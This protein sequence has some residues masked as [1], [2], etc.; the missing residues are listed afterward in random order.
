MGA[1]ASSGVDVNSF[2]AQ[3]SS[4]VDVET[5]RGD[6]ARAEVARLRGLLHAAMQASEGGSVSGAADGGA[7]TAAA[8]SAAAGAG[9]GAGEVA[10]T[11]TAVGGEAGA[12]APADADATAADADASAAAVAAVAAEGE[13]GG[14]GGG[15]VAPASAPVVTV[16]AGGDGAGGGNGG[17]GTTKLCLKGHTLV[18]FTTDMDGF[19]CSKCERTLPAGAIMYGSGRLTFAQCVRVF[20]C[21][22]RVCVCCVCAPNELMLVRVFGVYGWCVVVGCRMNGKV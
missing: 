9:A 12:E 21:V 19:G 3:A 16:A 17:G 6:A 15:E 11:A 14:E 7:A 18:A 13:A 8:A 5:P 10:A 20:V 4:Q 22:L 1:A 2:L